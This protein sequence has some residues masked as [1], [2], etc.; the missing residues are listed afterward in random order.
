MKLY[1]TP[2]ACSLAVDI[3]AREL[4]L[5]LEIVWVDMQRKV[6]PDGTDLHAINP[7]G[8]VP[9]LQLPDGQ[10]LSEGLAIMQYLADQRP[11]SDLATTARG[12]EKYRVLEWM[13]FVGSDLHKGGFMPL[14]KKTTPSD[15]RA[16]AL[17]HIAGRL[18]WLDRHLSDRDYLAADRFTIA[19]AHC[20]AIVIWTKRHA[21]DI[22]PWPHLASY[23]ARIAARASV[24]AAV[25]AQLV[26]EALE[27]KA[28]AA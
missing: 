12:V 13:S 17:Q 15:Y 18:Q 11:D 6:L 27:A 10:F 23:M 2:H 4:A 22:S 19:D 5:P 1:L 14:F 16:I 9:S 26:Q 25:E 28:R 20:Y 7:K 3:V 21:I 24:H 8:Q